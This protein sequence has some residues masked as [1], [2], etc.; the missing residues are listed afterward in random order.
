MGAGRPKLPDTKKKIQW[1]IYL[2]Q[3]E[4]SNFEATGGSRE[5]VADW[6]RHYMTARDIDRLLVQTPV[7]RRLLSFLEGIDT[8][9]AEAFAEELFGL[10][11]ARDSEE[12]QITEEL[13]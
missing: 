4:L 3:G 1:W 9:E 7:A 8:P 12:T 5:Q 2:R 6:V 10:I 11:V 13:S